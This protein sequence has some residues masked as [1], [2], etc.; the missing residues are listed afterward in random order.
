MLPE[1]YSANS[2]LRL[3]TGRPVNPSIVSALWLY[4][5]MAGAR[6]GVGDTIEKHAP[7]TTGRTKLSGTGSSGR[8]ASVRL[9]HTTSAKKD[10]ATDAAVPA[11]ARAT[12]GAPAAAAA[13][14]EPL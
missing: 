14:T 8:L 12:D 7:A 6:T 2:A 5:T 1:K 4:A 13:L 9:S 10:D 3:A 11:A